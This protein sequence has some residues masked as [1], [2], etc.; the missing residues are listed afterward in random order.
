VITIQAKTQARLPAVALRARCFE[1]R[2]DDVLSIM[3]I[4][5]ENN[6]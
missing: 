2:V 1:I 3:D 4:I 5:D 6:A